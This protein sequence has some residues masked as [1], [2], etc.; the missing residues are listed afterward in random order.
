[1]A[2]IETEVDQ[3][4]LD[5]QIKESMKKIPNSL[6]WFSKVPDEIVIH[7]ILIWLNCRDLAVIMQFSK[8]FCILANNDIIWKRLCDSWGIPRGNCTSW[9]NSFR[10]RFKEQQ[11]EKFLILEEKKE[12]EKRRR[13]LQLMYGGTWRAATVGSIFYM[14]DIP[15]RLVSINVPKPGK[16]GA[17]KALIEAVSLFTGVP[18]REIIYPTSE[19][20]IIPEEDL[21]KTN[22]QL[23]SVDDDYCTLLSLDAT[24]TKSMKMPHAPH[25][26]QLMKTKLETSDHIV[27][28]KVLSIREKEEEGIIEVT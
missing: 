28:V 17:S 22:F 1:M 19:F 7:H 3:Q 11:E 23:I 15:Y 21:I 10:K 25:L 9:K 16:Y 27:I 26:C 2:E 14:R 18:I 12:E 20:P 24:Y 6:R 13:Q 5:Y 8:K 4:W